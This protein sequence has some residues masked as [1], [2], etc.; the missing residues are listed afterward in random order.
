MQV[1][2]LSPEMSPAYIAKARCE[3]ALEN[4]QQ[5]MKDLERAVQIDPKSVI[6]FCMMGHCL[7]MMGQYDKAI[8]AYDYV[9]HVDKRVRILSSKG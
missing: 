4:T 1:L 7:A 5:A 2:N 8:T 3:M 9:L 6:A